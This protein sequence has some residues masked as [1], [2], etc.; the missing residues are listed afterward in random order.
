MTLYTASQSSIDLIDKTWYNVSS[1][2]ASNLDLTLDIKTLLSLS[3]VSITL[4]HIDSHQDDD[5]S[6]EYMTIPAQLNCI[7][8]DL[9][10]KQYSWPLSEHSSL[11]PHLPS[12]LISFLSPSSR[13]Q[14]NTKEEIIR[15]YRYVPI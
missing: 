2:L 7:A 11:L 9:T 4:E 13:L 12:Q 1:S 10:E 8:D 14:L 5:I 6:F 3:N 15:H